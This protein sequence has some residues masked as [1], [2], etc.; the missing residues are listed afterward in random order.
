MVEYS[1]RLF[2]MVENYWKPLKNVENGLKFKSI[3]KVSQ[4]YLKRIPKVVQKYL[5][6]IP[7]VSQK[8]QQVS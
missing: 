2:K 1:S 6:S 8:Y 3:P 5:K 7:K 4:M